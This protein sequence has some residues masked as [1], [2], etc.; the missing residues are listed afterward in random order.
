M[1]AE[2][3]EVDNSFNAGGSGK[4]VDRFGVPVEDP[5][6]NVRE[7][8]EVE[9][10]HAK[11]I[12]EIIDKNFEARIEA[13]A[14]L[15]HLLREAQAKKEEE[16]RLAETR[17]IDD[18]AALRL[19]YDTQISQSRDTQVKTTSDLISKAL[20]KVTDSLSQQIN[21][22]TKGF[23][24]QVASLMAALSPRL[25]DLERFRWESGGQ[26]AERDP[27]TAKA[28]AKMADA[29]EV[30]SEGRNKSSGSE[31]ASS[32]NRAMMISIGAVIFAAITAVA[33]LGT[34][35]THIH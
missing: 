14:R 13:Q 11:E 27:A 22:A 19:Q 1:T 21:T 32:D 15:D 35:L 20:D 3:R 16:A 26:A 29:I 7:L 24:D 12:R 31:K 30:L 9:K 8:V 34:M 17:R 18:L 6:K 2:R 28:L 25:A 10:A 5:T 4:G 23:S 33:A